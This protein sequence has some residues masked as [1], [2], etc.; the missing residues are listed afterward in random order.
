MVENGHPGPIAGE[1]PSEF[2]A[3]M[4]APDDGQPSRVGRQLHG[5]FGSDDP[6]PQLHAGRDVRPGSGVDEDPLPGHLQVFPIRQ[7]YGQGMIIQ[8]GGCPVH[9]GGG[10]FV[11]H[12]MVILGPQLLGHPPAL[13]RGLVERKT[14]LPVE[15]Q[16]LGRQ[17][18]HVDAGAPIHLV[19]FF[20]DQDV[21]SP[22]GQKL[23]QGLAAFTETDD[24]I[25]EAVM[26]HGSPSY[27]SARPI[28]ARRPSLPSPA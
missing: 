12:H 4:A 9:D 8:E 11:G 27:R 17:A 6:R 10:L 24:D 15:D 25:G 26:F 3:D 28:Q 19:G 21:F 22:A 23:S 18:A 5:F 14:F 13:D 16:I 20:N 1:H 7:P 2:Q